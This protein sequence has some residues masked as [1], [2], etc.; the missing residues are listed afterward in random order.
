MW[1]ITNTIVLFLLWCGVDEYRRSS[2]DDGPKNFLVF[3]EILIDA[4]IDYHSDVNDDKADDCGKKHLILLSLLDALLPYV[5]LKTCL[6]LTS[7]ISKVDDILQ[8]FFVDTF[9]A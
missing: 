6:F 8:K 5:E 4:L 3:N 1:N 9:Q 7:S 2:P